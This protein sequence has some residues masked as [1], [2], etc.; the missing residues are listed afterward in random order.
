MTPDIRILRHSVTRLLRTQYPPFLLGIGPRPPCS[1][2]CYHEVDR[3][4]FTDDLRFLAENGYRTLS[5]GEFVEASSFGGEH[6]T[7]RSRSM[8]PGEIFGRSRFPFCSNSAPAPL[9]LRRLPGSR[10]AIANRFL[11][12]RFR[13]G[14]S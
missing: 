11:R 8:T 13:A 10:A 5:T 1:V 2:F 14:R 6:G 3:A 7:V 12:S 4:A 9:C